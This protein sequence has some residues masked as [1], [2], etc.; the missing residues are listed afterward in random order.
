MGFNVKSLLKTAF[1]FIGT[2]LE[3]GGMPGQI[4]A[5]MLGKALGV[6][7]LEPTSE[8]AEAAISKATADNPEAM[9]ELRKVEADFQL[10][11]EQ[12]GIDSVEKLA[13]LDNEDRASARNREIAVRDKTPQRLAYADGAAFLAAFA[14]LLFISVPPTIHDLL[15]IM[16]T[17]LGNNMIA[18]RN[19]YFGS[20]SGSAKKTDI[21]ADQAKIEIK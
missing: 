21:M 9:L 13:A 18:E 7:K 3:M 17:T 19:Y 1:P 10:R 20:S 5:S 6:D 2:A 14:A 12:M 16:V 11:M 15:L 4:A 8:A